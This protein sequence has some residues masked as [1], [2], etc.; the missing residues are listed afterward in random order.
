M[1]ANGAACAQYDSLAWF[2]NRHW[3]RLHRKALAILDQLLLP[4]LPPGGRILDLCCGA[5]H[6]SRALAARGYKV[7]GIDASAEMLRYARANAPRAEFL[8]ADARSFR[9]PAEY[10]AVVSTF[11]SLNHVLTLD[12][13]CAVFANVYAALVEGG[14]FLFDLNMQEAYRT[15]WQKSSAL[16]EE[17]NACFVRGGYDPVN[18]LGR[19]E[20][21]MFRLRQNWER[22]DVTLFQ[23]C[24][25]RHEIRSALDLAGFQPVRCYHA[26]RDLGLRGPIAEGRA[27]FLAIKHAA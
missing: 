5:G 22:A 4:D 23:R 20:I 14:R 19:T 2:Y 11:D 13:L 24:Y 1:Q 3:R 16:V 25:R 10:D 12:Q 21:T 9:L 26:R 18:K 7:T 6:L 15:Q 17:D 27:V 8:A